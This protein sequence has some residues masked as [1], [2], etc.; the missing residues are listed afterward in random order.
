MAAI[1]DQKFAGQTYPD[2]IHDTRERG[3]NHTWFGQMDAL[4]VTIRADYR[5]DSGRKGKPEL[6]FTSREF[7]V[8]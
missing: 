3:Y 4:I 7:R 6:L 1:I 2:S 8:S 5:M